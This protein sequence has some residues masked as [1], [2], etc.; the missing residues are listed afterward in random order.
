MP[1]SDV[2]LVTPVVSNPAL[3]VLTEMIEA[4]PSTKRIGAGP[5]AS[6]LAAMNDES[7][8]PTIRRTSTRE[9]GAHDETLTLR[10]LGIDHDDE[11]PFLERTGRAA[12][13][14]N[15]DAERDVKRLVYAIWAVAIAIAAVFAYV[16][17]TG[18]SSRAY[19]MSA[20]DPTAPATTAELGSSP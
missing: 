4:P 2:V 17:V 11:F 9:S 13:G 6:A 1:R 19:K 7:P 15:D 10:D 8:P 14:K 18:E 12:R 20:P 16:V 3:T 5:L